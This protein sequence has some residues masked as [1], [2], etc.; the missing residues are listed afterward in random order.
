M[1]LTTRNLML[2]RQILGQWQLIFQ[3][4]DPAQEH[5]RHRYPVD[6]AAWS[7]LL[8]SPPEVQREAPV[9]VVC[10]SGGTRLAVPCREVLRDFKPKEE[11]QADYSALVISFC[12]RCKCSA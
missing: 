7:Y 1:I 3:S 5:F 6:E 8:K 2:L 4:Y 12:K 11:G 9:E 10:V